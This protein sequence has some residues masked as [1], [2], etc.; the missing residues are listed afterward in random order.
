MTPVTPKTRTALVFGAS[1]IT[2]WAILNEAVSYPSRDTFSRIIGLTNQPTSSNELYLPT[3]ERIILASGVNLM[4]D[5]DIVAEQLKKIAGIENVTDVFFSAYVQPPGTSDIEGWEKLLEAN[6]KILETAVRAVELVSNKL[7]FW[8]LQTGGKVPTS[9]I[10]PH[11]LLC[12][13][14]LIQYRYMGRPT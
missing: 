5:V 3:D 2:G 14:L 9:L 10:H 11:S 13:I 12:L 8:S 7:R 4:S 1:G 6:V